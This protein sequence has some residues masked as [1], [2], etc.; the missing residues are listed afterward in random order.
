M[1]GVAGRIASPALSF[2]FD[3]GGDAR[4]DVGGVLLDGYEAVAETSKVGWGLGWRRHAGRATGERA[5]LNS[6]PTSNAER[7]QAVSWKGTRSL[8]QRRVRVGKGGRDVAAASREM[9]T[10]WHFVMCVSNLRC[11]C[12]EPVE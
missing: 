1:R 12:C 10:R 4:C 3:A 9:E 11:G 8:N 2:A 5:S 7:C 6:M